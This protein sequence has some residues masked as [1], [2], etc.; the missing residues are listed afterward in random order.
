MTIVL[1]AGISYNS[2]STK[3]DNVTPASDPYNTN[4]RTLV[5]NT[6][7]IAYNATI[8]I[9]FTANID[10]G[11][12]G[13]VTIDPTVTSTEDVSGTKIADISIT[14][15]PLFSGTSGSS[16]PNCKS[17]FKYCF[18]AGPDF[19]GTVNMIQTNTQGAPTGV[20][21]TNETHHDDMVVTVNQIKLEDLPTALYIMMTGG[22]SNV[23][24]PTPYPL[25][26]YPWSQGYNTVSE[27]YQVSAVAAFNGY[28]ILTTDNPFTIQLAYD[29]T[30]LNGM[31]PQI[32]KVAYFDS[33][34]N[35]W[36]VLIAPTVVDWVNHAIATTTRRLALYAL[37]YP[38]GVGVS[39]STSAAGA[40]DQSLPALP[41]P[42]T[43]SNN[44]NNDL[45]KPSQTKSSS[46]RRCYFWNLVCF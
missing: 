17:G 8:P 6:D 16:D 35:R 18:N 31:D 37:V 23:P 9:T 42:A 27:I 14:V 45:D 21:V 22:N 41:Q 1:P 25:V 44:S 10:S 12:A 39:G 20:T 38:S 11:M 32:I 46:A 40:E 30:K 33:D 28:P 15:N 29:L 2:N 7:N 36:K 3:V 5:I 13:E 24:H 34:T 26:P 43:A 19:V 4:T